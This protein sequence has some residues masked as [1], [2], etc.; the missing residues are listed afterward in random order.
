[1]EKQLSKRMTKPAK[2]GKKVAEGLID[3]VHLM[4]QNKHAYQY[5]SALISGLKEELDQ[6]PKK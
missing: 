2:A 1:M 3:T 5:L 4:Y 6:R